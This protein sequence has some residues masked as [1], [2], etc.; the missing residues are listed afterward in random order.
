MYFL[1]G[2]RKNGR[3]EVE[4]WFTHRRASAAMNHLSNEKNAHACDVDLVQASY[5]EASNLERFGEYW[6]PAPAEQNRWRNEPGFATVR[7]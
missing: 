7:F 1:Q 6:V 4:F 2:G 5:K 3:K